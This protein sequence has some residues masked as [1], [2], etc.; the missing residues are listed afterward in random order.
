MKS[1]PDKKTKRLRRHA[2]IRAKVKGTASR[3]RLSIFRSNRELY[4]QLI[5]DDTGVTLAA[6]TSRGLSGTMRNRAEEAGKTLAKKAVAKKITTAVFDR[7][8]YRYAGVIALFAASA[9]EGGISF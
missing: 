4:A 8:G 6:I 7:G 3:P 5:D 9:R 1:A 2:R